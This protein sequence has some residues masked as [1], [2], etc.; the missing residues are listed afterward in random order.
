MT[1]RYPRNIPPDRED[2]S[3]SWVHLALIFTG[4]LG[5]IPPALLLPAWIALVAIAAWPWA[6]LIAPAAVAAAIILAVDWAALALLPVAGRSWGPV[7]P[8]LLALTLVRT[9]VW[10]AGAWIHPTLMGLALVVLVQSAITAAAIYATWYEPFHVTV[11]HRSYRPAGWSAERPLRLLHLSDLHFEGPSPRE[12]SV[13]ER[14]RRLQPDAIVITGDYLNLSSVYDPEAQ[15]GARAFLAELEAPAGVYAITG[16]PV[17]DVAGIVPEIF[18]DLPRIRWLQDEVVRVEWEENALWLVGLRCTYAE[19]RDRATL[20]RLLGEVPEG[21]TTVLLYH[22]PDLA[23]EIAETGIDLYL[24]GHTHGGQLRL[25]LYGALATSSRWGKRYEMGDYR[26]GQTEIY[27]SR[28][29]GVEGL[30][31][32]R[33]RFLASPEIVLWELRK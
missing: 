15:A 10:W 5:R 18:N 27:V 28:G 33:A 25:P 4:E 9:V 17:V 8:S 11:T 29:L 20:A 23:P 16:S 24:C 1:E 2:G 3:S 31:A 19:G 30:G 6:S 26:E 7:T 22:T 21:A 32:P 13:L 12:S 14:V